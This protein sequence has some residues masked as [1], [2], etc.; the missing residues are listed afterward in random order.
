M[1]GGRRVYRVQG[2]YRVGE[3]VRYS[4]ERGAGKD[5]EH[6]RCGVDVREAGLER[7]IDVLSYVLSW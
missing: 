3:R 6:T 2:T 7:L 4:D 1:Y 5:E